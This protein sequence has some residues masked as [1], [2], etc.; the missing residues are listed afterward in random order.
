MSWRELTDFRDASVAKLDHLRRAA[1]A[2][3][4]VPPTV[5]CPAHE[6]H[7]AGVGRPTASWCGGPLIVRSGS[8]TED[9][10]DSTAAGQFVTLVVETADEGA[11]RDALERVV[12]AL[13]KADGRPQGVVFVQPFLR[14]ERG[15]IAFFDGYYFERTTAAGGNQELT[16]GRARGDVERGHLERSCAWSSWLQR[17]ARVFPDLLRDGGTIDIEFAFDSGDSKDSKDVEITL[18]QARRAPFG[19]RRNPTLSLANHREI[20][21]DVPSPWM[22]DVLVKAGE[23]AI[24]FFAEIDPVVGSWNEPYAVALGGR[25]WLNVTAFYRLMDRWGLP[26]TFVTEGIG[27]ALGSPE[28]GRFDVGRM[29][30]ASPRLLR[31]QLKNLAT[32]AG[33]GGKLRELD[34][35]LVRSR[36]LT[37]LF[38]VSVQGLALALRTNFAINGALT[39]I[40]RVRRSLGLR[41]RADVVTER[42]MEEYEALRGCPAEKLD[43]RLDRWLADF[44]HRGPLESD[45]A[46]PRFFELRALLR[47]ELLTAAPGPARRA[48][49]APRGRDPHLFQG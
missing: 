2:G 38:D 28:D 14:P 13:P 45:L 20:L 35:A 49:S 47:E 31:L 42:M 3:V 46:R 32:V 27:G 4:R 11:F 37:D 44:G 43:T 23:H 8:P 36:S 41:G 1:N 34:A 9:R 12:D 33:A 48:S 29:L 7:E 6:A 26:R 5:W 22:V 40:A 19:V 17:L 24:D 15:G 10:A 39:G 30:R 21:G 16:S 18:L 25:A